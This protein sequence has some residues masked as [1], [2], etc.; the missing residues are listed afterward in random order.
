MKL[1]TFE[2]LWHE[3]NSSVFAGVLECP[4]FLRTRGRWDYASYE[5]WAYKP[6]IIRVGPYV[7]GHNV[8]DVVYHEMIHQYV[9]EWLGLEEE[10]HHGEI[11]WRNYRLFAPE[12]VQLFEVLD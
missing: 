1:R 5:W 8:R 9:E 11:F 12:G 4:R 6:S 7:N 2:K 3:L 10:N